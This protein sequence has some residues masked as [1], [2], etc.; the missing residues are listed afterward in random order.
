M[1]NPT[2]QQADAVATTADLV[3]E[4]VRRADAA[5]VAARTAER[6]AADANDYARS[7]GANAE[8]YRQLRSF[9]RRWLD[10]GLIP[11]EH[12]ADVRGLCGLTTERVG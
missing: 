3:A 10:A 2:E 7:Q 5:D 9:V 8:R 4:L 11:D 1:T 6:I 12:E